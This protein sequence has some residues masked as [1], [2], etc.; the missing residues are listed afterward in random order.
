MEKLPHNRIEKKFF[1]VLGATVV[2]TFISIGNVFPQVPALTSTDS[3]AVVLLKKHA[4]LKSELTKNTYHRPVVFESQENAGKVSSAVYAILDSPFT[5]VSTTFRNSYLW[6][7]VLILHLNTKYCHASSETASP[8]RLA[9]NV[10]KKTPQEL[11]DTFLL[12]FSHRVTA[13][14][15]EYFS[16]ELHANNGPL[17]TTDY[18]LQL[19]AIPLLEGKTFIHL[20][21][22]Y[23]YG[24]AGQLAMQT[25]LST[26]GRGKV[27]FTKITSNEQSDYVGGMRGAIERNTMRYYLAIEAYLAS[28]QRTD[29]QTPEARFQYWFDATQEYALQLHEI[30]RSSYLDMKK[31]EYKRQKSTSLNLR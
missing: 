9:V 23:G 6:C 18:R 13:E 30:D 12:E 26:L 31:S 17:N 1:L 27:G 3:G 22:S 8:A 25:Y 16:I 21:Y 14:T 11:A 28:L 10:G 2:L 5:T 15:P 24:F 4:L 7:E 29:M 20:H 19:R